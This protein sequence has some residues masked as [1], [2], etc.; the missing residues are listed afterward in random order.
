MQRGAARCE[1][2]QDFD[3]AD[4]KESAATIV[5]ETEISRCHDTAVVKTRSRCEVHGSRSIE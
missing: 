4:E 1:V 5:D 2:E 3:G